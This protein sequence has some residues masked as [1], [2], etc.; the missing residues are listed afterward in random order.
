MQV[1]IAPALVIFCVGQDSGHRARLLRLRRALACALLLPARLLC[2]SGPPC[3][4]ESLPA[5]TNIR[6]HR[7]S[8]GQQSLLFVHFQI[9]QVIQSLAAAEAH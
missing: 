2:Q 8:K 1:Q 7:T 3:R 6:I 4:A 9:G 5:H